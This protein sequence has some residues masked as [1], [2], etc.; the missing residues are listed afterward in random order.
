MNKALVLFIYLS[1]ISFSATVIATTPSDPEGFTTLFNGKDWQGWYLK[2]RS[3]DAEMAKKVFAIEDKEIHVFNDE[4]PDNYNLNTGE[5]DTHGLFYTNKKYTNYILKFEYKW[6][7][8]KA[9][10]FKQWQYDAGVYYHVTKDDVWPLGIEYQ[11][12][13]NHLNHRNHSGDFIIPKGAQATWYSIT[14]PDAYEN[15]KDSGRTYLHPDEGGKIETPSFWLKLAKPTTNFHGLDNKWNQVE[16]IVMGG[17]YA[18]HKLNGEVVNM[19]TNLFPT[20]GVIGFQAETSEVFYRNIKIKEFDQPLPAEQFLKQ[21]MTDKAGG[22]M[23]QHTVVFKLK[24]KAGSIQESRFLEAARGLSAIKSVKNFKV[25]KQ[26]SSKN[27]FDFGLSM[28]FNNQQDYE[29]YNNHPAHVDF[30]KNRWMLEVEDFL[31]IDYQE[32]KDD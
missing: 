31:E 2:L 12:R 1:H 13:Y 9:N 3:G 19:A 16:M 17:E 22:K 6:G 26:V 28:E 7:P 10:N 27:N 23:I 32:V 30:V 15:K 20:S 5:N 24:H 4:F 8:K 29:F 11:L 25:L 18:I 21:D 14:D